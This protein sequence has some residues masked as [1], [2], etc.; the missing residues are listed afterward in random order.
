MNAQSETATAEASSNSAAEFTALDANNF[1]RGNDGAC[2]II[3]EEIQGETIETVFI[4]VDR[5]YF[6]IQEFGSPAK[7]KRHTMSEALHAAQ[8][9]DNATARLGAYPQS[10]LD[11]TGAIEFIDDTFDTDVT[12]ARGGY[13]LSRDVLDDL[14]E[15]DHLEVASAPA[16]TSDVHGGGW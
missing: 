9:N 15:D 12:D 2:L 3:S 7:V 8:E 14:G 6:R 1:I 5:T 10:S 13:G 4:T 11:I 16:G